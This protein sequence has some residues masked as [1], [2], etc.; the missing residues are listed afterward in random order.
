FRVPSD[1]R[2]LLFGSKIAS[3]YVQPHIGGDLALFMG[4]AKSLLEKNGH[5]TAFIDV[6]TSGFDDFRRQVET[7]TWDEI[8]ASSGTEQATIEQLAELYRAS[9]NTVFAWAMGVTHHLHGTQTVQSIANLA[10]LRGMVG[11]RHA[12]MMPIRGHSNVQGMGSVGVAPALKKAMLERFEREIGVEP[13][14]TPGYD[15]MACMEAADRGEMD[16][17][18][19]LGGNL[20]GSNPD[21]AF[22]A[23]ALQKIGQVVYLSTTLNTGH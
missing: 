16:V 7:T 1:V 15:T 12:G 11:R 10:L 6:H 21:A 8:A 3:H 17:A 14:Q 9:K 22:A 23:R 13:P 18:F 4:M 2:S 19:C 20:Y 5:D